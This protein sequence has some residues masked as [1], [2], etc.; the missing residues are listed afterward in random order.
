MGISTSACALAHPNLPWHLDLRRFS[1]DILLLPIIVV[2][3]CSQP[4]QQW[5]HL[6]WCVVGGVK[7][8]GRCVVDR[9]RH[10]RLSFVIDT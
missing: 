3:H 10:P 4:Q 9:R 6:P 1:I 5:Q 8:S 2:F 7:A